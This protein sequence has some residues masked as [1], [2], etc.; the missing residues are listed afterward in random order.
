[1]SLRWGEGGR[2]GSVGIGFFSTCRFV[3]DSPPRHCFFDR[4]SCRWG[5]A[6]SPPEVKDSLLSGGDLTNLNIMG[7]LFFFLPHTS[8]V[9]L[10]YNRKKDSIA[11]VEVEIV[12]L[13]SELRE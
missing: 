3:T 10:F 2:G 12:S 5:K 4:F 7:D 1:M 9:C 11:W 8:I 6:R 13:N